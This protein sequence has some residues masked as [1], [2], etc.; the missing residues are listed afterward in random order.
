[1]DGIK[2]LG[3]TEE[4]INK[5][6]DTATETIKNE[7]QREKKWP[8]KRAESRTTFLLETM[9]ARKKLY[10]IFQVLTENNC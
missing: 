8:K 5:R 2:R 7:T 10:N 6:E 1:M 9:E 4:K 3:S